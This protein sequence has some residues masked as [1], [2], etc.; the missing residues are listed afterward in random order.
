MN[1]SQRLDF[2]HK[3]NLT[4][5]LIQNHLQLSENHVPKHPHYAT[6]TPSKYFNYLE[7]KT[8]SSLY[9]QEYL[10]F[11][12]RKADQKNKIIQLSKLHFTKIKEVYK[13]YQKGYISRK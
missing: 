6:R 9:C 13:S 8:P 3:L 11:F 2:L 7:N 10:D 5:K 1:T 12:T 4:D